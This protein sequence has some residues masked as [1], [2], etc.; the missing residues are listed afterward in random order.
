[1]K[2]LILLLAALFLLPI[3]AHATDAGRFQTLV[4]KAPE[5]KPLGL[6]FVISDIGGWTQADETLTNTLQQN[7]WLAVGL[8]LKKYRDSLATG[9][10]TCHDVGDEL[11]GLSQLLQRERDI[12]VYLTPVL[13]GRG[14]GGTLAYAAIKQ[15]LPASF[16]GGIGMNTQEGKM[17][18]LALPQILCD[19]P[20]EKIGAKKVQPADRKLPPV[21]QYDMN[22][23]LKV[24]FKSFDAQLTDT[25]LMTAVTPFKQE[26]GSGVSIADL[27]LTTLDVTPQLSKKSGMPSD[28]FVVF[29]SG[30]G[31]WRDLDKTIAEELQKMGIPVVGWDSLRYF[32]KTKTPEQVAADLGRVIHFYA[33]AWNRPKV[34]LLGYSFGADI[35]PFAYNRMPQPRQNRV[36]FMSLLGFSQKAA[37]EIEVEG[38]LGLDGDSD[39]D[40]APEVKKLPLA[41]VQ[42]IY[43]AEDAEDSGCPAMRGTGADVIMTEGG[44]H[45]DEGYEMIARKI[46][47]SIKAHDQ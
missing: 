37:L 12:D 21:W 43:G 45:F 11:T 16:R 31:G 30:D 15:S 3:T 27:P 1:M 41:R 10:D 33:E 20:T 13:I 36:A 24:P 40:T 44:H 39:V 29:I 34:A 14:Q 28:M 25:G 17:G 6:A 9:T 32:W 8:D 23:A 38:Y 26:T 47:A 42:C 2:K 19:G 35:I 46:A 4:I 5:G 18:Q 7:S 22:A